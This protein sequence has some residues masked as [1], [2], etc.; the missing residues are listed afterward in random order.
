MNIRQFPYQYWIE[1]QFGNNIRNVREKNA[2]FLY[3]CAV[4]EL[5]IAMRKK[6]IEFICI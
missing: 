4:R 5:V 3:D 2:I 6:G 1:I